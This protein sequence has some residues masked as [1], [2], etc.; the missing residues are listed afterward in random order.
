M[1]RNSGTRRGDEVVQLYARHV[2]SKLARSL[3]DLRGFQRITLAPGQQRIVRFIV[4]SAALT[5]WNSSTH[6]WSLES[7][8]VQFELG[9]SAADIRA[10]TSVRVMPAR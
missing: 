7:D 5:Y 6:G 3:K 4:P 9:A 10:R 1:V 2:G 8:T